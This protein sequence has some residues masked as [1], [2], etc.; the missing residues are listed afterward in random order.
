[1]TGPSSLPKL[2]TAMILCWVLTGCGDALAPVEDGTTGPEDPEGPPYVY[3]ASAFGSTVTPL[4]RGGWPAWSPD[5]RRIAFHRDGGIYVVDAGGS[6]EVRLVDGESPAWSPDGTRI[7]FSH[8]EHGIGLVDADGSGLTGLGGGACVGWS[9]GPFAPSWAPDGRSIAFESLG[10]GTG[11][12]PSTICVMN[13][14]G[15]ELRP[16]LFLSV[17][18]QQGNPIWSPDG[19]KL[20]FWSS[21]HGVATAAATGGSEIAVEPMLSA[22]ASRT[23]VAWSPDGSA[24][25]FTSRPP[26]GKPGIWVVEAGGGGTRML[27]PDGYD[28][29]WSPDGGRIAFVSTRGER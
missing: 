29:A 15:S 17:G 11:F 18:G 7:A 28:A 1:M 8:R 25:A 22:V 27:I 20:A 2:A 10:D 9:R 16:L 14:D 21:R 5:G 3:V 24:I 6:D 13:V 23:R 19:T 12:E 4:A 26:L